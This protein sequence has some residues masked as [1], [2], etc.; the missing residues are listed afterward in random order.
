[1]KRMALPII[2]VLATI[3]SR[4]MV[5]WGAESAPHP[6]RTSSPGNA[7]Y[8]VDPQS[9]DD[10]R[11]GRT[12]KTSWKTFVPVNDLLLSPGDR[13]EVVASGVFRESLVLTGSG[14]AEKPV[15]IH[16]ASGVYDFFPDKA[17]DVSPLFLSNFNDNPHGPKR[18]AIHMRDV[19]HMKLTGKQSEI[20]CNGQMFPVMIDHSEAVTMD[21]LVFDYHR[22]F[23]SEW[24]VVEVAANHAVVQIHPDSRYVI[25]ENRLVWVGNGWRSAGGAAW[26][27]Q[28]YDPKTKIV[29]RRN[30]N[31][32]TNGGITKAE[33]VAPFRVKFSFR[34]NPGFALGTTDEFREGTREYPGI[35]VRYCKNVVLNNSAMYASP[36]G[37]AVLGM[38]TD[39]LTLDRMHIAPRPNSGRTASVCDDLL[40]CSGCK[41]KILMSDCKLSGTGDDLMN[42]HGTHLRISGQPATNQLTICFVHRQTYG[43][44]A[45]SPGDDI[46][47]VNP[48]SLRPYASGR[49]MAAEMKGE[50]EML[51]TLEKPAP[52]WKRNDVIENV[53]WTPTVEV[54]NCYG[55]MSSCRGFLCTT[56]KPVLIAN[57]T[58]DHIAMG[59]ILIE[60]DG[61]GW[62]ESGPCRDVTIRG[63]R[64]IRCG[65]EFYYGPTVIRI[66]PQKPTDKPDEPAHENIRI[67]DNL[68][69][70]F[71]GEPPLMARSVK[72]LVFTGNRLNAQTL[73]LQL[74]PSCTDVVIKDNKLGIVIEP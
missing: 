20:F 61:S 31:L 40:H 32:L 16:F 37:P 27:S 45:F 19:K 12:T 54:R 22:P 43:F 44:P 8:F 18:V 9:G 48:A 21:G 68:F 51:L 65:K 67:M 63:N 73:N 2:A 26:S 1:M 15:E 17:F 34:N 55:S 57:N 11:D 36:P 60:D 7:V 24:K 74:A 58:F 47:F 66:S 6:A 5:V 29:I 14:T 35:L 23:W 52:A 41:G 50:R 33:E 69:D 46:D 42:V 10:A 38:F 28:H 49:V 71:P 4:S 64:F 3:F 13:V 56:R 72:G 62:F 25:E 59:A 30:S 70:L 39:G 53:T